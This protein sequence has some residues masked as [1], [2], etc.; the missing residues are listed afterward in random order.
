MVERDLPACFAQCP[1]ILTEGGVGQRLEHEY[2]LTPDKDIGYAPLIYDAK[3]RAALTAIYRS[4]LAVAEDVSLPMLLMTNTRRANKDRMA[5][6]KHGARSVMADYAAFLRELVAES[7]CEAYVGG[8]MGCCGDAYSGSEGLST[9]DAEAFHSWQLTQFPRGS[10]DF[11]FAGIMPALPEAL[12]VARLMAATELP[13]IISLMIG[14]DGHL[15]DGTPLR[16]AID[17]IDEGTNPPPLCYMTNCVHPSLLMEALGRQ[18]NHT[19]LVRRRF[20]G[21]QA[22]AA[23]MDLTALDGSAVLH[24]SAPEDW[25]KSFAALCE[26]FPMKIRGG[27][28]GTTDA[29][30]RAL[31]QKTE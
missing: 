23:R 10:I 15:L 1:L 9:E 16:D 30:I 29:H 17:A 4:Y 18:V 26:R 22:N 21:I 3:G 12:G 31:L 27:C 6:S 11:L 8:M 13:Y 25:A 28:C 5:R 14:A 7:H 2:G 24:S 20:M 19:P